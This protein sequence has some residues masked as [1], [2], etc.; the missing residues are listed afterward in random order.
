MKR[1]PLGEALYH[2]SSELSANLN[3]SWV[4]DLFMVVT[5]ECSISW[6]GRDL[7]LPTNRRLL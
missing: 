4:R 7:P 2:L 1:K 6:S 5:A 3:Y